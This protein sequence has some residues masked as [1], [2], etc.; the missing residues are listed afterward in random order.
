[1]NY[2]LDIGT[3]AALVVIIAEY[4]FQFIKINKFQAQAFTWLIG[5]ILAFGSW[6]INIGYLTGLEWHLVAI[7]GFMSALIANGA[8]DTPAV[9]AFLEMIKIRNV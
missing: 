6:V 8:F 1:M 9:K 7:H 5:L 2:F 4:L 3:L